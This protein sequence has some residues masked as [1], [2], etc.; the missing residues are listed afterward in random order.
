MI[1]FGAHAFVRIG[2]WTAEAGDRAGAHRQ[3]LDARLDRLESLLERL[4]RE[5]PTC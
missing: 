2:D 5:E 4:Q 1:R 3:A